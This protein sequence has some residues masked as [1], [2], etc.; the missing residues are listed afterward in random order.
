[1][2]L[3]KDK[4]FLRPYEMKPPENRGKNNSGA[5]S[6]PTPPSSAEKPLPAKP[7]SSLSKP[8]QRAL[9][10]IKTGRRP[11]DSSWIKIRLGPGDFIVLEEQLKKE[12]LWGYV[13]DKVRFDYN[14]ETRYIVFRMPSAIHDMFTGNVTKHIESQLKR[15]RE[16]KTFPD[17]ARIANSIKLAWT[18]NVYLKGPNS[19]RDK[20]SPDASFMLENTIYPCIVIE[21]SYSQKKKDL[22]HLADDYI[23]KSYGSIKVMIGLDIEYRGSKK[24]T[25]S[26]WHP[27]RGFT[28]NGI[29]YLRVKKTT[30]DKP[31]RSSDGSSVS[32]DVDI[33]LPFSTFLPLGT[34]LSSDVALSITSST[35]FSILEQVERSEAGHKNG[36]M[37]TLSPETI[38]QP[39]QGTPEE[40]LT[41]VL[42]F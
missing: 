39:Q 40:Q 10:I 23:L 15:I 31:F 26:V 25:V 35:L 12:D 34:K 5:P 42:R 2:D 8:V 16:D 1:M 32:P 9:E 7:S 11:N 36:A 19:D 33:R 37:E 27:D 38:L 17:I 4:A 28:S 21:T 18:S 20:H 6:L 41:E 22:P 30:D 13:E 3:H 14:S 29:P 24:A